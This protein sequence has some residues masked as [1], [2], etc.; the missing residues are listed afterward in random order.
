MA[1][2]PFLT[3]DDEPI[4]I[5]QAV[6][7]LQ[8]GRKFDGF[9]G[10]ILRQFVLERQLKERAEDLKIN[11]ATIEQAIID[12]RLERQL[13]DS[14][15]FQDWL[16]SNGLNYEAFH[17]QVSQGFRMRKLRELVTEPKLQEYFIE[18]KIFLD[19]VVLSRIIVDDKDVA[20]ELKTQISEETAT[21]EQLAREYSLTDDK[22]VNGMV[23]PVSRGTMPDLLRAAIDTAK[24]GDIVGP[25]GLEERWGLFRVEEFLYATLSDPQLQ[26]SLQD[27]LFEQ[28]LVE[29]MQV[30]PIKLQL[31]EAGET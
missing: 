12:F 5:T 25:I 16:T 19:R 6:R 28:W 20:D 2:E 30:L 31:D 17:A 3:I 8:A 21:F 11:A 4:T 15:A 13:S 27:E 9:I 22:I 18:R 24:V 14:K 26:T 10:E 7:Y 1:F 23:G 29:K